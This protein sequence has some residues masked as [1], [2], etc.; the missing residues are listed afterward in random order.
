MRKIMA[1]A[2][3][4]LAL[5]VAAGGEPRVGVVATVVGT[6]TVARAA[7]PKPTELKLRDD[8]FMRDQITTGEQ[9]FVR[10]LLG[11]KA[12]VSAR[13][14][15]IL[16]IT[17]R[18]SVSTV[19]L[20]AGRLAAAVSKDR[21][22]PGETVEIRVPNAIVAIRGTVVVA[23][24]APTPSGLRSTIT[25]LRGVVEV[26]GLDPMTDQ[27]VGA[28]VTVSPPERIT[29]VG[30]APLPSPERITPDAA[31]RLT[32]EFTVIPKN[33]PNAS[34]EASTRFAANLALRDVLQ[35]A[36]SPASLAVVG[37]E[38]VDTLSA[39]GAVVGGTVTGVTSSVSTLGSVTAPP[40]SLTAPLGGVTA[41]LGGVTAPLGSVTAPLLPKLP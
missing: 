5:P 12:A 25:I 30:G 6:A 27:P 17:E 15:S 19:A 2:F 39:A 18:P 4:I 31:R 16:R 14:H 37:T 21:V 35:G 23:E 8:V 34:R 10:V 13:E 3:G 32:D 29:V 9:S 40:G 38:P 36:A 11:G 33:A 26:R 28:P 41:P 22:K 24:V 7:N 20:A 1:L